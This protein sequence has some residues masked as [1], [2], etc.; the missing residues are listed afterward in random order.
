MT[1]KLTTEDF[2]YYGLDE[3]NLEVIGY[4]TRGLGVSLDVYHIDYTDDLLIV[5][6]RGDLDVYSTPITYGEGDTNSI[7]LFDVEYDFSECLRP[8]TVWGT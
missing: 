4:W 5:G 3:K 1:T 7:S 8:N 6:Y 2:D